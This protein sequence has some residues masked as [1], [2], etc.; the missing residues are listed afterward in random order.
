MII[1]VLAYLPQFYVAQSKA[2]Y[3]S[4]EFVVDA[5]TTTLATP[6]TTQNS[7][8]VIFIVSILGV[9]VLR[10]REKPSS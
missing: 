7:K 4:E 5:V 10:R 1:G 3:E 2:Y 6:E 9:L 8:L